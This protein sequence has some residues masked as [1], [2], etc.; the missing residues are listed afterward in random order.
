MKKRS[1]L[2]LYSA[3]FS[4]LAVV[5]AGYFYLPA[6]LGDT[7]YPL[8]YADFIRKY[9][10][11][12]SVDPALIAAVIKQESN[13]NPNAQ[14]GAGA[15]GLSQFMDGT[16]R[17]VAT[18]VGRTT[19]DIFDPETAVQF[20]ARHVKDLLDKYKGNIPAALAG[21]NAGTGNADRWIRMGLLDN[22]PSGE[23]KNYVRN[24]QE[25]Q[26]IYASFYSRE[27]YGVDAKIK[28]EKPKQDFVWSRMIKDLVSVVYG[29]KK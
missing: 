1:K 3:L 11:E 10:A 6:I 29:E 22:L 28:I 4:I 19:Y 27:L 20:C 26:K 8:K 2:Q 17:T 16:A 25:Y 13:F 7:V 21:Y 15:K 24:V 23:T 5:A 18:E 14:S 12:Y 9:S